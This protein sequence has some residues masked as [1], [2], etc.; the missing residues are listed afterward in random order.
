MWRI[1]DDFW[2]RWDLLVNMFE[3][4]EKWSIH[5]G[6]G[7]WPD[8]DMLPVGALNQDMDPD[9]TSALTHDE[10]ITMM[11]LWCIFRSPL[12][13]GGELEK[14]DD[15][16]LKLLTNENVLRMHS[17]ARHSH[18]VFRRKINGSECVLWAAVCADGGLYAA[19]FNLG[20]EELRGEIPFECLEIEGE[21]NILDL[22]SEESTNADKLTV[23]L[24]PH[25][26]A[27]FLIS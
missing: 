22:W 26:S 9:Y 27:A 14:T 10:Q 15:F 18:Q 5:T 21:K 1:T 17:L 19:V 8:C 6:A 23:S 4:C 25:A 12:I 11:N 20:D 16:T 24:R 13:I 2:D 3:R 7:N